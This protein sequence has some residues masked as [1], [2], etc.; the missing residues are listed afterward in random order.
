MNNK[1]KLL[2]SLFT[3]EICFGALY[4]YEYKRTFKKS[5][6][7]MRFYEEYNNGQSSRFNFGFSEAIYNKTGFI[8]R[9]KLFQ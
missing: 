5:E 6:Y 3:K 7:T 1:L 2:G 4:F 8:C 9:G